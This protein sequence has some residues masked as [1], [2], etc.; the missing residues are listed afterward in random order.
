MEKI[1]G[2]KYDD[3]KP[4]P[5]LVPVEAIE[6]IMQKEA[7]DDLEEWRDK[8]ELC[9]TEIYCDSF[10]QNCKNHCLRHLDVRDCKEVMQCGDANERGN[11]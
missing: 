2:A 1:K 4:R 8:P 7:N 6:A 9:C 5:S 10:T 11:D 3:G